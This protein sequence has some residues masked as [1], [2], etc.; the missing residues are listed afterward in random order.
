MEKYQMKK[1]Y[2]VPLG[3]MLFCC[4]L[5]LVLF[6]LP[7]SRYAFISGTGPENIS[8]YIPMIC[9]I[10]EI[11]LLSVLVALC[12][13]ELFTSKLFV[14]RLEI[15]F[16]LVILLFSYILEILFV[17]FYKPT[18]NSPSMP[19]YL[20]LVIFSLVLSLVVF[21]SFYFVYLPLHQIEKKAKE[22][23]I[24]WKQISEKE[25]EKKKSD[26][27]KEISQIDTKEKMK[28]YLKA[29]YEAGDLSKEKYI[30]FLT[31]LD[32]NLTK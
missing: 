23:E 19:Y 10:G 2:Y 7:N 27:Q 29:K 11:V 1:Q 30:E 24:R 4:V 16:D 6:A 3:T 22:T 25:E 28:E 31:D 26:I 15:S 9:T 17:I 18:I 13:L 12:F 32:T 5:I 21:C 20:I 8:T 14:Y